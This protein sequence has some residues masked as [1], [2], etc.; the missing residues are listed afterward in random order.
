MTSVRA[1]IVL[2]AAATR[3]RGDAARW[4]SPCGRVG[5]TGDGLVGG[6]AAVYGGASFVV[7]AVLAA[8]GAGARRPTPPPLV[9][10]SGNISSEP[11]VIDNE[12]AAARLGPMSDA[13]L[14]HDPPIERCVDDSVILDRIRRRGAADPAVAGVC[15]DGVAAGG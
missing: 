8:I 5:G 14:W 13:I 2:P 3:R 7:L 1:P 10:T 4:A 6:H 11:L 12:D 15:A 9:M